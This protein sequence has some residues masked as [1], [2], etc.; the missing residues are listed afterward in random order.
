MKRLRIV[1]AVI[2]GVIVLYLVATSDNPPLA[3]TIVLAIA[4][5][6]W[7]TYRA[8]KIKLPEALKKQLPAPSG[9]YGSA[10]FA[11]P[12]TAITGA[13]ANSAGVF[14]GKSSSP[15]APADFPLHLNP[16]A[17]VCSAPENHTLIVAKTGAGKG[18]RVIIP[19]LLR[20]TRGSMIVMDPKGTNAAITARARAAMPGSKVHI[21]NPWGALDNQGTWA[22]LG[23]QPATFNPLD[24]LQRDDPNI[25]GNALALGATISPS[26][27]G[28][29]QAFWPEMAAQLIAAIAMWLTYREGY[30]QD[31]AN[32]ASPPEQKTLR[33]LSK[34]FRRPDFKQFLKTIYAYSGEAFT[35]AIRDSCGEFLEMADVT[36]SGVT[37]NVAQATRFLIDPRVL[38]ATDKSSFPMEDL[39]SHRTTIYI[40]PPDTISVQAR[41][42]RLLIAAAIQTLKTKRT[43]KTSRCMFLIDEF[44]ALGKLDD[45]GKDIAYMR[46]FG[47]DFVLVVQGMNQLHDIYGSGQANILNNCAYKWYCNV[48]DLDSAKYL[49][50]ILGKKTVV[51]TTTSES[52]G[53]STGG[54][55]GAASTTTSAGMTYGETGKQLLS[56]DE[57]INNLGRDVAILLGPGSPPR[58]L[59]PVDYWQLPA[60]FSMFRDLDPAMFWKP[61]L[62]YDPNPLIEGSTGF[63]YTEPPP[64]ASAPTPK[65][66]SPRSL[67]RQFADWIKGAEK[68]P[69]PTSPAVDPT[70]LPSAPS[71][72]TP[73]DFGRYANYP[74]SPAP[75]STPPPP[76]KPIDFMRYAPDYMKN[77]PAPKTGPASASND[78]A[79]APGTPD[80]QPK[81]PE[82]Q[83]MPVPSQKPKPPFGEW[84]VETDEFTPWP[85]KPKKEGDT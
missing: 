75:E 63:I 61:P 80:G 29:P 38:D 9:N 4:A 70:P 23:L 33:R 12:V 84:D 43:D 18:T 11:P 56:P 71:S 59:R 5:F 68:P 69:A 83:P 10:K 44:P 39:V 46:E 77:P 42:L 53:T 6:A 72:P 55:G 3:L 31:P 82:T 2:A 76:P 21:I 67:W 48:N 32:A 7:L 58:Y 14:F 17:P 25:V 45:I 47:V 57:I 62:Q 40:I 49:S 36:Y 54:F 85:K 41:W 74:I 52:T 50:E 78:P 13:S 28:E 30:P 81:K 35:G 51:T 22:K 1:A 26:L 79:A 24:V 16:G 19:T 65:S 60:A 34:I 27:P 8:S 66:H 73:I 64:Q 15:E 37:G 20:Y